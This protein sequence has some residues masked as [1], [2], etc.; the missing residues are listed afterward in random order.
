MQ[1]APHLT[2]RREIFFFPQTVTGVI[3]RVVTNTGLPR[4]YRRAPS[5]LIVRAIDCPN[6]PND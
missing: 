6:G 4:D 5:V 3:H 1:S 2:Q